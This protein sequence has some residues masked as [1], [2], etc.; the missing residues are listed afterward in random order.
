MAD[1]TN[2]N[3][4]ISTSALQKEN[5]TTNV[6]DSLDEVNN[7]DFLDS[8][9]EENLV[10]PDEVTIEPVITSEETNIADIAISD[11]T[12]TAIDSEIGDSVDSKAE[13]SEE[14]ESEASEEASEVEVQDSKVE[15]AAQEKGSPEPLPVKDAPKKEPRTEAEILELVSKLV[16]EI[17]AISVSALS[18]DSNM[19]AAGDLLEEKTKLQEDFQDWHERR[20]GSYAWKL[21]N[22]LKTYRSDLEKDEKELRDF[23]AS[24][25]A[26]KEGFGEATRKWFMKRFWMNFSISWITLFVL[27]LVNRF[28]D[29]ISTF[30]ANAFGGRSFLKQGLDFALRNALGL[31][32]RQVIGSIFGISFLHFIGLLFAYSRRNSEH[33]QLVAE[34]SAA[35]TAMENGI[36][37]VRNARERIDSLHPQVP[38]VIEV[39]SLGLHNPWKIDNNSLLFT[40]SVPNTAILPA[41]VEVAVPTSV[42]KSPKYEE[43]VLRTMNKIQIA[44]WRDQA[45]KKVV[46]ELAESIGFGANDMA[47]RELDEDQRKSGKRQLLIA[48]GKDPAPTEKIGIE[49]VEIFTKVTQEEVLPKSQPQIVSLRPNP[50]EGLELDGSIGFNIQDGVSKWEVYLSEIAD[51]A[52]PWSTSTFSSKGQAQSKH[53]KVESIFISSEQVNKMTKP[54]VAGEVAVRPGARPFEVAIRVDFSEWCKPDEVAIFSDF[55]ATPEQIERWSRGGSTHGVTI[56]SDGQGQEI[57]T[58]PDG[59]VL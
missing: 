31:S 56:H 19:E 2:S 51:L 7:S 36:E 44:G 58:A 14:S 34:E 35:A 16:S 28:S 15:E 13:L 10:E 40:G 21:V 55:T 47:V 33:S 3:E 54:G 6:V 48:A 18:A 11:E 30:L 20:K 39:L 29:Q 23:A 26:L 52:A 1:Q 8:N 53:I 24:E 25:S 57:P 43:L 12:A 46:Q 59:L 17:D 49:Q 27:Y 9:I 50:L 5:S 41:S 22:T 37:S 38:Q 32:L 4:L 42:K 45:F